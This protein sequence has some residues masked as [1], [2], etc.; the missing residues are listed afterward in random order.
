M[1]SSC[2]IYLYTIYNNNNKYLL[3]NAQSDLFIQNIISF[4]LHIYYSLDFK[5][6]LAVWV[7]ILHKFIKTNYF[8][9]QYFIDG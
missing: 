6:T 1:Y 3:I 7:I 2:S 4:L 8:K 5:C 9:S